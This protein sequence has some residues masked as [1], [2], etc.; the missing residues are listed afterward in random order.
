MSAPDSWIREDLFYIGPE[1]IICR[2]VREDEM[3]DILKSCHD[4]P[5]RGHFI[6][7]KE[8]L[9]VSPSRYYWPTLFQDV[10]KHV[11]ICDSRQRMGCAVLENEMPL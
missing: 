1:M 3:F 6:D 2:C 8:I 7:T 5:C 9:Q 10:K 4:E 11:R